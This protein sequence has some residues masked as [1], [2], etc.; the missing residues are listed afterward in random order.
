MLSCENI[1]ILQQVTTDNRYIIIHIQ[2]W[3][4]DDWLIS[5][6]LWSLRLKTSQL[7]VHV[8][9]YTEGPF[10]DLTMCWAHLCEAAETWNGHSRFSSL[11]SSAAFHSKRLFSPMESWTEGGGNPHRNKVQTP[12][13][14]WEAPGGRF[15]PTTGAKPPN[16]DLPSFLCGI[17]FKE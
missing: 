14:H 15:E 16:P 9:H 12:T 8:P 10:S 3:E 6:G 11:I 7:T 17:L 5:T 13:P 1:K 4:Q 2:L